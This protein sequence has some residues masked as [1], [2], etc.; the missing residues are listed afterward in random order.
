MGP[1]I[2]ALAPVL[3]DLAIMGGLT[4]A[5]KA[6]AKGIAKVGAKAAAGALPKIVPAGMVL[7]RDGTLRAARGARAANIALRAGQVIPLSMRKTIPA[8]LGAGAAGVVNTGADIAPW[9]LLGGG[10]LTQGLATGGGAILGGAAN[11]AGGLVSAASQIPSTLAS[12]TSPAQVARFGAPPS[13]IL[14]NIIGLLGSGAGNA[15]SALGGG[16]GLAVSGLGNAVGS[17]VNDYANTLH[18]ANMF[19]NINKR[20]MEQAAELER[21]SPSTKRVIEQNVRSGMRR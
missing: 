6:A 2:A 11:A 19:S 20:A 7:L 1:L 16:A 12:G 13:A 17:T 10:R 21:L 4:L 3:K 18:M 8:A 14:G 9:L 15:L 5:G